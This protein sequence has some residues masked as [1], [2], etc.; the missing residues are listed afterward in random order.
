MLGVWFGVGCGVPPL[1]SLHLPCRAAQAQR[2]MLGG[3]SDEME[4]QRAPADGNSFT[5]L[6]S[7][8][9]RA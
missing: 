3:E 2:Q 9:M 5:T 7:V 6:Y 8:H 1:P 4:A